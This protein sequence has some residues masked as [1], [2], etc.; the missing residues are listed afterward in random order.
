MAMKENAA[1]GPITAGQLPQDH[2][3]RR[4]CEFVTYHFYFN[5]K[6]SQLDCRSYPTLSFELLNWVQI[7]GKTCFIG[8]LN[9][10]QCLVWCFG[11][12]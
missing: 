11:F 8:V 7:V 5:I 1:Y 12:G 4:K 3:D 9:C 2:N 10:W 6:F